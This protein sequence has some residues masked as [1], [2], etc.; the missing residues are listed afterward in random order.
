MSPKW[1]CM[2][3]RVRNGCDSELFL[4][5]LHRRATIK[6]IYS[7]L[8]VRGGDEEEEESEDESEEVSDEDS[9][10]DQDEDAQDDDDSDKNEDSDQDDYDD[11]DQVKE[12]ESDKNEENESDKKDNKSKTKHVNT[13]KEIKSKMVTKNK[14]KEKRKEKNE[15]IIVYDEP[16]FMSPMN[17]VMVQLGVMMLCRRLNMED[18]QVIR[19]AR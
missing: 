11:S 19:I 4:G 17:G 15:S 3:D 10:S 13:S 5:K 1:A 16:L 14:Y 8:S 7:S 18:P 9:D 2:A 6:R 12:V